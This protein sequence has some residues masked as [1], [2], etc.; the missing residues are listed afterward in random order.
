ML[1]KA[2][3]CIIKIKEFNLKLTFK[4]DKVSNTNFP[5]QK[6]KLD[7]P[8]SLVCAGLSIW[9]P[10]DRMQTGENSNFR[11]EQPDKCPTLPKGSRSTRPGIGHLGIMYR[12][13]K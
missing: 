4:M 7:P 13:M 8:Q 3:S 9:L 5:L 6:V 10:K 1:N 11:V 12:C 2:G